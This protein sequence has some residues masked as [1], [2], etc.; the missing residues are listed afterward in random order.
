[1]NELELEIDTSHVQTLLHNTTKH[2]FHIQPWQLSGVTCRKLSSSRASQSL[3]QSSSFS[4]N[5]INCLTL[6]NVYSIG[7]KSGGRVVK[8]LGS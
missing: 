1:M 4:I 6:E 7:A 2:I 8:D 3:V 5:F